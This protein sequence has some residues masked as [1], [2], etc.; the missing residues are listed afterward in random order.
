MAK[1]PAGGGRIIIERGDGMALY[2]IVGGIV[3]K[4][5][6]DIDSVLENDSNTSPSGFLRKSFSH[7]ASNRV[8]FAPRTS[9]DGY[10]PR[11]NTLKD[12]NMFSS[13]V[14]SR[15]SSSGFKVFDEVKLMQAGRYRHKSIFGSTKGQA[16]YPW[17]WID[18]GTTHK[19]RFSGNPMR[20]SQ[21]FTRDWHAQGYRGIFINKMGTQLRK[22]GWEVV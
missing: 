11:L 7:S 19:N 21:T 9:N 16:V 14:S 20:L 4:L 3:V 22:R 12:P 10:P 15:I 17:I 8:Y 1:I 2:R 6:K 13:K 18:E 5:G